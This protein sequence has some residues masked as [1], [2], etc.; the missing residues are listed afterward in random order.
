MLFFVDEAGSFSIPMERGH[1]AAVSVAVAVVDGSWEALIE[2]YRAFVHDLPES[3]FERG[4][5][6]GR[7]LSTDRLEDFTDV[8]YALEGVQVVPVTMD[9]GHLHGIS[10]Q[11]LL[12]PFYEK[13]DLTAAKMVYPTAQQQIR[14]LSR[15]VRNLSVEQVLRIETWSRC[16]YEAIYHAILFLSH[17]PYRD[18]W[19]TV[20]IEIDPVHR[21]PGNREQRV[22]MMMLFAWMMAWAR[23]RPFATIEGIHTP[24]LPVVRNFMD[25]DGVVLS[26]L[27]RPN[28]YWPSSSDSEGL[29]LADMAA[30]IV[31]R[32]AMNPSDG[33][34]VALFQKLMRSSPYGSAR[35][36]GLISPLRHASDADALVYQPL[37]EPL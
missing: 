3:A 30:T 26:D 9:L 34:A 1:S 20:R 21:R 6:K 16:L 10:E 2:G 15:Q 11:E 25:E 36:P 8:L 29:Q 4:E 7:R 33:A 13:L 31:H 18:A 14:T 22:I 37:F 24:D 5:P 23:Q 32:A 17:G 35:G 28:L 12:E 19:E 27:I